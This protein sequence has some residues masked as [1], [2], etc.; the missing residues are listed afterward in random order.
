MRNDK[1]SNLDG[2]VPATETHSLAG[3]P[4][5]LWRDVLP[6]RCLPTEDPPGFSVS[7]GLPAEHRRPQV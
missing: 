5:G 1:A 6:A 7:L 3:W 4:L 2:W